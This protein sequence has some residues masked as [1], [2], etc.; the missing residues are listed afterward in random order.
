MILAQAS[1]PTAQDIGMFILVICALAPFMQMLWGAWKSKGTKIE[2]QPLEVKLDGGFVSNRLFEAT[3]KELKATDEKHAIQ[4]E[5]IK[6]EMRKDFINVLQAGQAREERLGKKIEEE[7]N[8]LHDRI[9]PMSVEL[10][11]VSASTEMIKTILEKKL[12]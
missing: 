2:P 1:A 6:A 9:D 4:I 5:A 10:S 11:A 7:T 3:I 12:S 8:R